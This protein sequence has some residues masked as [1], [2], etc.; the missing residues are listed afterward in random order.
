MRTLT[1]QIDTGRVAAEPF[2][3]SVLCPH[4]FFAPPS[5]RR[6]VERSALHQRLLSHPDARVIVLQG[7]AGHGKSTALQQIKQ[8]CEAEGRITAWLSF[9]D[10]DNDPRRF[11][12]H[13]RALVSG[14]DPDA[15]I[16]P[17][18]ARS[19]RRSDWMIECLRRLERPTALFLDEFQTLTAAEL[20]RFFRELIEHLPENVTLYVG[21]RSVPEIGLSRAVVEGRALLIPAEE[22]RFS[23]DEVRAFFSNASELALSGVEVEAI[24]RQTEGWPA[25][26]QLFRLSLGRR[27]VRESL[28]ALDVDRPRE[29][30]D[31]LTDNVLAT[32]PPDVQD[33]LLRTAVLTR[34]TAPLCEAVTG[35]AGAQSLLELLERSGLFLRSLDNEM[36]WFKYHGLFSTCLADQLGARDPEALVDAHR[37][38]AHWHRDAG[39]HAETVYHAIASQD[40]DLAADTLDVWALQLVPDGQLITLERWASQIPWEAIERRPALIVKIAWAY[41]FLHRRGP[42]K[43]LQEAL[44]RM[45]HDNRLRPDVVLSM[46]AISSDDLAEAFRRVRRVRLERDDSDGYTAFELGAAG[47]LAAYHALSQNRFDD[48]AHLIELAHE[49][50]RRGS[51]PFSGGYNIALA[52]SVSLLQG[53]LQGALKRCRVA[54]REARPLL[55]RSVAAAAMNACYLWVLYE[56][57]ELDTAE[58]LFERHHDIIVESTLPDFA[59]VALLSMVRVCDARGNKAQADERLDEMESIARANGWTRM[60][61]EVGWERV[62]RALS[63]GHLAYAQTLAATLMPPSEPPPWMLFADDLGDPVYGAIRLAIHGGRAEHAQKL[64]QQQ[65]GRCAQRPYA[66]MRLSLL[67]ARWHVR[68]GTERAA[69]RAL[70]EALRVGAT[71]GYIGCFVEE[72]EDLLPLLTKLQAT[73]PPD[74]DDAAAYLSRLIAACGGAADSRAGE[75]SAALI[76]DLTER[77]QAILGLLAKGVSNKEMARRLFVSENTVKFHLKNIYAKLGVDNRLRAITTA[78]SYG[79]IT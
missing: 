15:E 42:L 66:R 17:P 43:P 62:R 55:D 49:H 1:K 61:R 38:A 51:S 77:E 2:G 5:V 21:S 34:L 12:P 39:M 59:A 44:E 26:L 11:F 57:N 40:W 18:P 16:D 50:S 79:L 37:R 6:A 14:L 74:V 71:G 36:R 25:A 4:K 67:E 76:E 29:L 46:A 33:F 31:Y 52:A 35:A 56:A 27:S 73:P 68:S 3:D 64:L 63:S 13:I 32:Q 7:P 47:N 8:A 53:D 23:V 60:L 20:L 54:A 10:A 58:A 75:G 72:R 48:A 41:V 69:L 65:S 78:R 70:V 19:R 30:A 28:A 22:L 45:E 9:D 24:Y